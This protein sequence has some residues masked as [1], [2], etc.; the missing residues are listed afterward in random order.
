MWTS[1]SS[2]RVDA[3]EAQGM[4]A[5]G[6]FAST[7]YKR[8]KKGHKSGKGV[9]IQR[10]MDKKVQEYMKVQD[11]L[12]TNMNRLELQER[13]SCSKDSEG[14]IIN[15][16]NCRLCIKERRRKAEHEDY[17]KNLKSQLRKTNEGTGNIEMQP[18]VEKHT[19]K[20]GGNDQAGSWQDC[21]LC[22]LEKALNADQNGINQ[23]INKNEQENVQNAQKNIQN[24]QDDKN[25]NKE[26]KAQAGEKIQ[27]VFTNT[28]KDRKGLADRSNFFD[29]PKLKSLISD[30]AKNKIRDALTEDRDL[31][32]KVE[33]RDDVVSVL[34]KEITPKTILDN[35]GAELLDEKENLEEDLK[36]HVEKVVTE[37]LDKHTADMMNV[38]A[39]RITY[40]AE[41]GT[42]KAVRNQ[43]DARKLQIETKSSKK[44]D[45]DPKASEDLEK[46]M[47]PDISITLREPIGKLNNILY[48]NGKA[49]FT[50]RSEHRC[51]G[52][53]VKKSNDNL[54]I[55]EYCAKQ[56]ENKYGAK[57]KVLKGKYKA[58]KDTSDQKIVSKPLN[59][60]GIGNTHDLK[61]HDDKKFEAVKKQNDKKA[62]VLIG[63]NDWRAQIIA[64][65]KKLNDFMK[66]VTPDT[67]IQNYGTMFSDA[68]E[69]IQKDFKSDTQKVVTKEIPKDPID[70]DSKIKGAKVL[71]EEND[72]KAKVKANDK[73]LNDAMKKMTPHTVAQ[74]CST[75]FLDS[76]GKILNEL[77][78]DDQKGVTKEIPK[79]QTNSDSKIKDA[80]AKDIFLNNLMK[81][82]PTKV[83][84][85]STTGLPELNIQKEFKT[86]AQTDL[87]NFVTSKMNDFGSSKAVKNH[88][89]NSTNCKP[90]IKENDPKIKDG[91]KKNLDEKYEIQ[92]DCKVEVQKA[93]E[94]HDTCNSTPVIYQN[95]EKAQE[96]DSQSQIERNC[97]KENE[98]NDSAKA[99][100]LDHENKVK[101][102]CENEVKDALKA[103]DI[104][105]SQVV[106]NR[107]DE[108]AE[109]NDHK[110]QI[111]KTGTEDDKAYGSRP[112]FLKN[113]Y[114]EDPSDKNM[115]ND[116]L[117]VNEIGNTSNMKNHDDQK[118]E[119][120]D[121][122][123]QVKEN[124]SIDS[125]K[126]YDEN[127]KF[128]KGT[129]EDLTDKNMTGN[130]SKLNEI[131]NKKDKENDDNA[132]DNDNTLQIE[133]TSPSD[134]EKTHGA[135]PKFLED[136]SKVEKNFTDKAMIG[137]SLKVNKI[138][139]ANN[140]KNHDDQK[141]EDTDCKPQ[142]EKNGTEVIEKKC[143]SIPK[144]HNTDYFH[145][146]LEYDSHTASTDDPTDENM[147]SYD[148]T[149]IEISN[150]NELQN[151]DDEK[152]EML[153]IE[154][155]IPNET[156]EIGGTKAV[157]DDK[158]EVKEDLESEIQP[159]VTD[160]D[161]KYEERGMLEPS[162]H[163][164]K[165]KNIP[166][167]KGFYMLLHDPKF[168]QKVD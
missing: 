151:H 17:L 31:K 166:L 138:D 141:A 143:G 71:K 63:G 144:F 25:E 111:K 76:T 124:S 106:E 135:R 18:E 68:K 92:E 56:N 83:M 156:E 140:L 109:D 44:K 87:M 24:G 125:E 126:N 16:K 122:K 127:A 96:D 145:E 154:Q 74:N 104:G 120:V 117:K 6:Y 160:G 133:E 165:Q 72:W 38:A 45:E 41:S 26:N 42:D 12:E 77:K 43:K 131:E 128:L 167:K 66:T 79:D 91:K 22:L 75:I 13:H 89:E 93:S 132:K 137:N 116:S 19:C 39:S 112:K 102:V 14:Q 61:S 95:D 130:T 98:I 149:V 148:L 103:N 9:T 115:N 30:E 90:Q 11:E 157:M 164:D 37:K 101:K 29:G 32:A 146:D 113:T 147:I 62:Q 162:N 33:A 27:S 84:P 7:K 97:E 134:D 23:E 53:I 107:N 35:Y 2:G 73:K 3:N 54:K 139:D 99:K 51:S 46:I 8:N 20:K 4:A 34:M 69:N 36:S 65:N 108:Q 49:C 58:P 153:Q 82:M 67:I 123:L 28:A 100:T 155:N 5:Q 129:Y 52:K 64:N 55:D 60:N 48:D 105:N 81:K 78:I 57:P 121:C 85:Y 159:S 168:L 47:S 136:A 10:Y 161:K 21:K 152:D 80:K 94:A 70:N 142:A 50:S 150:E 1:I 119:D 15:S 158:D 59:D 114:Q 86:I 110:L 88:D 118:V 40:L 163:H